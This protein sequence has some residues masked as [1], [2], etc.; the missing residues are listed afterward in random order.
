MQS[1]HVP[2]EGVL[3]PNK[4]LNRGSRSSC[5][6]ISRTM[7]SFSLMRAETR[8]VFMLVWIYLFF[9]TTWTHCLGVQVGFRSGAIPENRPQTTLTAGWCAVCATGAECSWPQSSA[10]V[11]PAPPGSSWWGPWLHRHWSGSSPLGREKGA[12]A[13]LRMEEKRKPNGASSVEMKPAV[14]T[15]ARGEHFLLRNIN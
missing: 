9:G 3:Y 4:Q 14:M 10:P 7:Y 5:S 1:F 11:L 8:L 15:W 2:R 12:T 6:D 13:V